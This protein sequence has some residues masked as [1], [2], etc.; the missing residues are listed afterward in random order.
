M[1]TLKLSYLKIK[2]FASYK[3]E[4]IDFKKIPPHIVLALTGPNGAGKSSI[5]EAITVALF[6][7][8]RGTSTQGGGLEEFINKGE[9]EFE[10]ELEFE[11]NSQMIRVIRRRFAK[12]GQELELFIDEVDHTDKIK[13]TQAKLLNII[14]IDY[15]TFID[16]VIIKQGNSGT[17]MAK[18]A[19]ERKE[20]FTQILGLD[21]YDVLQEYTKEIRKETKKDIETNKEKLAELDDSIKNKSM[22]ETIIN[23]GEI[24]IAQLTGEISFKE[25]EIEFELAEKATHEQ[26]VKQRNEILRRQKILSDKIVTTTDSISKGQLMKEKCETI[27]LSK[28]LVNSNLTESTNEL[29]SLNEK[30]SSLTSE[31]SNIEGTNNVLR[32]QAK[33]LKAKHD[34]M[35]EFNEAFCNFCGQEVTD[36]HKQNH[37]QE[38]YNEAMGYIKQVKEN[39]SKV[40]DLDSRIL[41]LNSSISNMKAIIQDLRS[42]VSQVEQAEVKYSNIITRLGELESELEET[43]T[44]YEEVMKI[45]VAEIENKTFRDNELRVEINNLRQQLTNWNSKIAV[46]ENELKK[47][48]K[49]ESKIIK[50][51][52]EI[53]DLQAKY[54]KLDDLVRAWGKEGI[55]AIIIDNA[56][57]EIQ[58]EINAILGLLTNEQVSIE[59]I[60]QKEK[61]KGKKVSSIET[62]DIIVSDQE[63]SRVYETYSGG[64][65]FRV[66]FACHVGLS[67]FL[68][69]RAGAA[70]D[71]FIVDEGIGSQDQL[72]KDNLVSVLHKISTQFDKVIVITHIQDIIEAF[73]D[74]IEVFKDPV[75]GSKVKILNEI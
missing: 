44:D 73:H 66:D 5:I 42:K 46:A 24:E 54:A 48:S 55:Q 27:L 21:K 61:G 53:L 22:Y 59:F 50:I 70:I 57:P 7:R 39:D 32:K 3:D 40:S 41:E 16:T 49:D 12:G 20:V 68:S 51:E 67:K 69:K 23:Q 75:E 1:R 72:A 58:D 64:E 47:I 56:L 31:K 6:N 34:K 52:N 37:M 36:E 15:D 74:K 2:N 62:L 11:I 4:K 43:R 26:L 8:A 60:T 28:D 14:K 25:S 71:L 10:I 65:K 13:E 17:F 33:E 18:P 19:N 30:K 9:D 63:G 38:L 29:E 35:K 45:E